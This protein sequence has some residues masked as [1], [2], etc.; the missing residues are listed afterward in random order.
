MAL[1]D[2]T[3]KTQ[4]KFDMRASRTGSNIKV[5]IHNSGTTYISN[6]DIDDED[7]ADITDWTDSSL[8]T[9][10]TSQV[11]FDG[12]S[13]MKL[14]TGGT[15]DGTA[16]RKQDIGTFGTRTTLSFN[17]YCDAIGLN[18]SDF[19]LIVY[20]GS[21]RLVVAFSLGGLV[22][23]NDPNFT[24][25]GTNLVVEDVWQEWTFD[26]NWSALTVSIYLNGVLQGSGLSFANN[27]DTTANGT[28]EF[29]QGGSGHTYRISYIDWFKAGSDLT[30]SGGGSGVT[31]EITPNIT[32]AD[33]YQTV[34]WGISAVA[35]V[36]KNAIDK[37]IITIVNADAA[38]TF[39]IDNM[40]ANIAY[41][42]DVTSGS[43]TLAGIT[44]AVLANRFLSASLGTYLIEGVNVTL[45][46]DRLL[47]STIGSYGLTGI[48]AVNRLE[49]LLN[50]QGGTYDLTG[51][52]AQALF[53]HLLIAENGTYDLTGFNALL[54][55]VGFIIDALPGSYNITGDDVGLFFGRALNA[56]IGSYILTGADITILINHVLSGDLGTYTILGE[57]ITFQNVVGWLNQ[58]ASDG[59][60]IKCG[61]VTDTYKP[62][63]EV[64]DIW[65]KL[66]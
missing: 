21:K 61:S 62:A 48:D 14:D 9:G 33:T 15:E 40:F 43:Y 56:G 19:E 47:L 31:T 53:G 46:I 37:I 41:S 28:V 24:E 2:L 7:M 50:T 60:W 57:D 12:K 22:I 63:T 52:E 30:T 58:Q 10:V 64:S 18:E 5:G 36:D 59:T 3:G 51:A 66:K 39:Y 4:I 65:V 1:I 55:G 44:S 29:S 27:S 23:Y 42:L 17:L 6:A 8:G 32:S 49:R 13:C 35:D 45:L 34:T 16:R 11:T 38:N 54:I 20:N 25:V 26:I